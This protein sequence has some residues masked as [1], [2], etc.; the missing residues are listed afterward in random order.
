MLSTLERDVS[1]RLNKYPAVSRG[2]KVYTTPFRIW[3]KVHSSVWNV[4]KIEI[5]EPGKHSFFGYYDLWPEMM[6]VCC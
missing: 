5:G 2:Q 3:G 4:D 1:N 6:M